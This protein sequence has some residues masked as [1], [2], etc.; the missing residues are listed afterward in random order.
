MQYVLIRPGTPYVLVVRRSSL[1]YITAVS[2]AGIICQ[3]YNVLCASGPFSVH[4]AEV[5]LESAD[6]ISIRYIQLAYYSLVLTILPVSRY[7]V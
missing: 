2:I 4:F 7:M 6:F 1:M 5:Y 3:H